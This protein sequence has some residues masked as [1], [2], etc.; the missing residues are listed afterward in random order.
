MEVL[1]VANETRKT[2]KK[3]YRSIALMMAIAI[4]IYGCALL[5]GCTDQQVEDGVGIVFDIIVEMLGSDS[6]TEP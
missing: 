5:A 3:S 4:L 1:E 6:E 2:R